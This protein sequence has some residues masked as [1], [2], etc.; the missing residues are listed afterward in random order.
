MELFCQPTILVV[1]AQHWKQVCKSSRLPPINLSMLKDSTNSDCSQ[2]VISI[3]SEMGS[4]NFAVTVIR[5]FWVSSENCTADNSQNGHLSNGSRAREVHMDNANGVSGR[6][7]FLLQ[8][9][10]RTVYYSTKEASFLHRINCG[11]N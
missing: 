7:S 5:N 1:V 6:E 11:M 4:N 10:L 9:N 2:L 8:R 3:G